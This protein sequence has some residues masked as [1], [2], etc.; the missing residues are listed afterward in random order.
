MIDPAKSGVG[1][2]VDPTV[3]G[4]KQMLVSSV[5]GVGEGIVS[6][7]LDGDSYWI[8]KPTLECSRRNI[9][10]K[11]HKFVKSASGACKAEPVMPDLQNV[12][13]LSDA[14]LKQVSQSLRQIEELYR[15]P[16][17]VEWAINDNKVYVLQTRPI[18][19]LKD[20]QTGYINL[21][22]NSN[23][24]ESYGGLTSPLSFTFALKNY[25]NVYIQFCEI[26]SVPP[27]LVKEMESYLGFML[28]IFNGRVF[29]NL[30]NW[31]KLVGVLPGFK[32]NKQFME[33]MMGVGQELSPE[34]TER[35]RPHPSWDTLLGKF[36]KF[37]TGL[38]FLYYHCFI[39]GIVTKFL[40]D[41]RVEY[42]RFRALDYETM[43]SDEI[44]AKY[45]EMDQVM[46]LRWKAPIINDF[47][48]MVHFGMLKKLTN[49][50][51][52]N[53]D[54]NIQN[55]L[56]AGEGNLESAEPTKTM[57]R[58]AGEIAANPAL[59]QLFDNCAP[60]DMHE[61]LRQSEHQ[62]FLAKVEDYIDRFGFRCMNEMK[63]E[64]FDLGSDPKFLF[65]CIKNYLN[66]GI[67]DLAEYE[68]REKNLRK[69]AEI[70][71]GKELSGVKK[72][73]YRWSLKHARRAVRN[74]E[75]T[76]FSRTR[77]YGVARSMFRN[78]GQKFAQMGALDE[79]EDIFYL[80]LGE[81]VGVHNGTLPCQNL[82]ALA[83]LR[84]QEYAL[85]DDLEPK[86]RFQTRGAVYWRNEY[87]DV[88]EVPEMEEG[89]DYDL[90]GLACC[91]GVVEGVVKVV[92]S[93]ADDM[94]MD[95]EIL[96]AKRTDPGWVPL[97]PSA[98]ALL[99]ERGSLLSHSAIVAR[100]MGIPAV[101]GI[102][103]LMTTLKSGMRVRMDG[104]AGTV[105]ILEQPTDV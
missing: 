57:I 7:E 78:M 77:A 34:V 28:G 15:Y 59:K 35:I 105:K 14:E 71:V 64:E 52:S 66:A 25:K 27:R 32:Q 89:A 94:T 69:N 54:T 92:H 79:G 58:M 53:L 74:R 80:E 20:N 46:L 18:T 62:D 55:D 96:V 24:V 29:Y 100:E 33:T 39:E 36:R 10:Q 1:F 90:R 103:G 50:W 84:K 8:D 4:S 48:C 73:V 3:S 68:Q 93:P 95:G 5:Y 42:D 2:S 17:D 56:L 51:L 104:T 60:E 31:Y 83:A 61:V 76:R 81:I 49:K 86:I 87:L 22:D 44:F 85:Y 65:V 40:R 37:K 72:I 11:E 97:F 63:L 82:K 101:V 23:I 26:L 38:A 67:T 16:Q 102:V 13:S 88:P 45:L 6:G 41:F 30:Y 19:T 47:L 21:W 12:S 99:V 43:S 98:S 75:N 9:V 91:P 70:A